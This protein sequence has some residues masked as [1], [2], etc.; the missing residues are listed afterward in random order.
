MNTSK[1]SAII[2]SVV[3]LV[4]FLSILPTIISSTKTASTG[5][6]TDGFTDVA[7]IIDL[8]PLV[9]VIGGVGI[10]GLIAWQAGK[11]GG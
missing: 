9:A 4:A 6:T 8:L 3:V 10:A 11:K 2:M 1:I 7:A 5:A